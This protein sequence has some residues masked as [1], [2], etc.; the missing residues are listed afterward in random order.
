MWIEVVVVMTIFTSEQMPW[1]NKELVIR[2]FFVVLYV[3]C[4]PILLWNWHHVNHLLTL[5]AILLVCEFTPAHFL[6][7][8]LCRLFVRF[9]FVVCVCDEGATRLC[10]PTRTVRMYMNWCTRH[11]AE[12]LKQPESFWMPN[13]LHTNSMMPQRIWGRWRERNAVKTRR[14]FAIWFCFSLKAKYVWIVVWITCECICE[15]HYVSL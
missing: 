13:C 9:T 5:T 10:W 15:C 1:I 8:P 6:Q 3:F 12:S 7:L 4:T 14:G 11:I 2:S